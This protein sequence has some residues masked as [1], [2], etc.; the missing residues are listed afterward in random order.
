MAASVL[1]FKEKTVTQMPLVYNA[2]ITFFVQNVRLV[3][4][5]RKH[6]QKTVCFGTNALSKTDYRK[7][8]NRMYE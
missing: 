7:V 2:A 8:N 4:S 3:I 5:E 6:L 1:L